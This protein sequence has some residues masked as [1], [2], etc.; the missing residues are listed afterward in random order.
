MALTYV[1]RIDQAMAGGAFS[2]IGPGD[3]DKPSVGVVQDLLGGLGYDMPGSGASSYGLF[4]PKTS[5]S[6][7]DFRQKSG[8]PAGQV[9]DLETLQA[10]AKAPATTA[11]AS[12]GYLALGLEVDYS[13][14]PKAL[15]LIAQCEGIGRFDAQNRNTDKLGLSYG[16]I[17]WAQRQTRLH[18]ILKAMNQADPAQFQ[19]VFGPASGEL[20][21]FVAKPQGGVDGNGVT[22]DPDFDL[23]KAPWTQRFHAAAALPVFQK[24]QVDTAVA[25]LQASYRHLQSYG[26][27]ALS[28]R[29][30]TFMLD[31]A[32]QYGDGGAKKRYLAA[33]E[34]GM[35]GHQ[36]IAAM[37]AA[38]T[39]YHARRSFF[40]NT[41]LLGDEPFQA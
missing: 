5:Q 24:A 23:V 8:L 40:L 31:F 13:S 3:T 35:S 33:R 17:Q 12:R 30:V 22:T 1:P 20:L 10:L 29:C 19:S 39:T 26:P 6:V 9:V 34:Q 15:S 2:P 7:A 21:A 27:E 28:E 18:D 36:V 32:N 14:F 11:R 37:T 25:A 41:Q 38:D 4:G 16:L